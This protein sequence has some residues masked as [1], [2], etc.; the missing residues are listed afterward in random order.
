[1]RAPEGITELLIDWGQGDQA[2]LDKLM[3]LVFVLMCFL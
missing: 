2:A 1:M 3:P